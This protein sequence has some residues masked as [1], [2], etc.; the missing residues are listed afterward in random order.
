[1]NIYGQKIILRAI[2]YEDLTSLLLWNNDPEIQSMLGGWHFPVSRLIQEK[3]WQQIAGDETNQRF[4]IESK[5]HGLIGTANLVAINWKD[6]NAATGLM[7]GAKNLR[8]Q[9]FGTDTVMTVM[10]Y[11]FEELNLQRLE[12]TI[13]EY[14]Q[15][16]YRLY[17]ER[18]GWREEGRKSKY[19]WR[20][21]RYWDQVLV[22]M[23]RERYY[24]LGDSN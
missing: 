8:R 19:Y 13:I 1:M 4:A 5:E 12:T 7:I 18:C 17:V 23:L 16:S 11:A 2:E 10:R 21:N 14:N 9:G 15:P 20:R 6:R 3:W 22:A 24:S